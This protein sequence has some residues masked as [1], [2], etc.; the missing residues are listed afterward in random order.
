MDVSAK[1]IYSFNIILDT[2]LSLSLILKQGHFCH[3]STLQNAL[4]EQYNSSG[5]D[6]EEN[7]LARQ[8]ES[9]ADENCFTIT[10]GQQIHFGLGPMYVLYKI[11]NT[12]ALAKE[13]KAHFPKFHFV[14]IFWMAAEDHDFEEICDLKLFG[15][16]HTWVNEQAGAVGRM[17]TA[18]LRQLITDIRSEYRL[19]THQLRFLDLAEEAYSLDNYANASRHLLHSLFGHEGLLILDGDDQ[20]LK[21]S[22][23]ETVI[24]ELKGDHYKKLKA[25][26]EAL[27]AKGFEA[28]IHIRKINLFY[29]SENSRERIVLKDG[30]FTAGD[31]LLCEEKDID[32]FVR[33]Q[34]ANI[35]PNVALRP[36][37][38]E[39]ILPN[40]IYVG[41]PAEIKYW[42]QLKGLFD[43][44]SLHMPALYLRTSAVYLGSEIDKGLDV[45]EL[46]LYYGESSALIDQAAESMQVLRAS[47]D[48]KLNGIKGE[49]S[50]YSKEFKQAV[51]GANLDGKIN[52]LYPKIAE[53]QHLSNDLIDQY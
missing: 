42:H 31:Q 15:R 21:E 13:L 44:Y 43:H 4:R 41:G 45:S 29:L 34:A 14:P 49:L 39:C 20:G 6:L 11:W 25:S 8:I 27:E 52:K 17:N 35:S 48:E 37:Y 1:P 40:L 46:G 2:C 24:S 9:L 16:S 32:S 10:T 19:S 53:L 33:D 30:K 5:I 7:P 12:L 47:F 18:G 28:Q 38:Q 3:M 36:L 50:S 22:W 26:T 23:S 51:K